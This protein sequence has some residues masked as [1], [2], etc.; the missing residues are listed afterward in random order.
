[1]G[2]KPSKSDEDSHVLRLPRTHIIKHADNYPIIGYHVPKLS[3]WLNDLNRKFSNLRSIEI[4]TTQ[5]QFV[6]TEPTRQFYQ[7]VF[8]ICAEHKKTLKKVDLTGYVFFMIPYYKNLEGHTEHVAAQAESLKH[9]RK[10]VLKAMN[11]E[12]F[13]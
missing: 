13:R 3:D 1:M 6:S 5:L 11:L 10:V 4:D 12:Y 7:K 9:L 2:P 8:E